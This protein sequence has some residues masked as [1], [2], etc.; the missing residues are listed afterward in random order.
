MVAAG[1][2]S[3]AIIGSNYAANNTCCRWR[4]HRSSSW[5]VARRFVAREREREREQPLNKRARL[6]I[7]ERVMLNARLAGGD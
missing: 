3:V 4:A 2:G 6:A 7:K 5:T 1:S